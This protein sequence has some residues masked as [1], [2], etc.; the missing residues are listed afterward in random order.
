VGEAPGF[1]GHP[2]RARLLARLL[3]CTLMF[4]GSTGPPTLRRCFALALFVPFFLLL[5]L[6]HWFGFLLDDLLFPGYRSVE[7]REPLFVVGLPRSGTTFLQRVLARDDERFTTLRLWELV[8]APSITERKVWAGLA[9]LDRGLGGPVVKGIDALVE[10]ALSWTDRVHP[11]AFDEPEEDFLLLLPVFAC[12]LLVVP[13]PDHEALWRLARFDHLPVRE[14]A[15][16]LSFYRSCL[17]RHLYVAGAE[18]T[19]LSKNPSFTPMVASLLKTFPDARF[20]CCVREPR[21]AVPSQ[22]SALREGARI[23][24]YR[25]DA[26]RVRDRFLEMLEGYARHALETLEPLDEARR[27]F[28]P[29]G[30]LHRDLEGEVVAFYRR[31]GWEPG[32]AFRGRLT[33]AGRRS[34]AYASTHAYSL[35][36]FGLEAETLD[37]R[38]A[39]WNDRFGFADRR[40][41]S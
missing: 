33:E 11:V 41:R 37:R 15:A 21:E 26:P 24:G 34:R 29:L 4:P 13:F 2:P 3:R 6:V 12:F 19:I 20:V 36:A 27:A 17:Q 35:E 16:I 38:F 30:H 23:F 18:K 25:I 14:R 22:L 32:P 10:G 9:A 7:V 40:R 1:R 39:G 8:L 5:Q 31:F 28:V